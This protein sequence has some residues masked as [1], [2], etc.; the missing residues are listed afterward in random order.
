MPRP[1]TYAVCKAI[2]LSNV[3]WKF[4]KKVM[5]KEKLTFSGWVRKQINLKMI[6][7]SEID[8]EKGN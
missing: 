3:Q 8:E 4:M 6:A 1:L 2:K 7:E 5:R